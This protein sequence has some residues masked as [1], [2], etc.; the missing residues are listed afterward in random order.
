MPDWEVSFKRPKNSKN[1]KRKTG[2][3]VGSCGKGLSS[4]DLSN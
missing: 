4:R 2:I 1:L 3:V